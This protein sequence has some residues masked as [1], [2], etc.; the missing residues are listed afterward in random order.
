VGK[1]VQ[2]KEFIIKHGWKFLVGYLAISL[3][4]GNIY[5]RKLSRAGLIND[6][7]KKA[8]QALQTDYKN[9]REKFNL[10]GEVSTL[11][12]LALNRQIIEKDRAAEVILVKK[13][14][15]IRALRFTAG[16]WESKYGTLEGEALRLSAKVTALGAVIEPLKLA[17]AELETRDLTRLANIEAIGKKLEECQKLLGVSIANTDSVIKKGW[18]LKIFDNVK[19][20]PGLFVGPDGQFRIGIGAVWAIN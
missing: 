19:F 12:I 13:E 1:G 4:V 18:M 5:Q 20:G 16:T 10:L 7:L 2:V 17:N 8:L 15:E 3:V 11:K 14:N 6:E 9:I